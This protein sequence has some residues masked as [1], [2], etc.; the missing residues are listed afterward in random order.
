MDK[1]D[2]LFAYQNA[3]ALLLG[4]VLGC[5]VFYGVGHASKIVEGVDVLILEHSTDDAANVD[6]RSKH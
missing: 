5:L 2:Q 4:E 3:D 6:E 1:R